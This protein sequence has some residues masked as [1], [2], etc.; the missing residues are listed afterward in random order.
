MVTEL[1]DSKVMPCKWSLERVS[2]VIHHKGR[3]GESK[4]ATQLPT[5]ANIL[6][7]FAKRKEGVEFGREISTE[8]I[9]VKM[10]NL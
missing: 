6:I 1:F 4:P 5:L 10:T 9:F 3:E 7:H 8:I 2:D